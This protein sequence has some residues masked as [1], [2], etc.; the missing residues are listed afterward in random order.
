MQEKAISRYWPSGRNQP[1]QLKLP[2]LLPSYLAKK[3]SKTKTPPFV[4][5]NPRHLALTQDPKKNS[6]PS[7]FTTSLHS[8]LSKQSPANLNRNKKKK[9]TLVLRS[10]NRPRSKLL[11]SSFCFPRD[12][13]FL[14]VSAGYL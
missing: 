10:L 13:P 3:K 7:L 5:K 14:L 6:L 2:L 9:R 12:Q 8:P 11:L 4:F 1:R